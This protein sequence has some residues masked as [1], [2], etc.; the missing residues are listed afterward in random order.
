MVPCPRPH[1]EF[2]GASRVDWNP[3][4]SPQHAPV[5][6]PLFVGAKG[7]VGLLTKVKLSTGGLG[8]APVTAPGHPLAALLR[9]IFHHHRCDTLDA[10]I[11]A[12][13]RRGGT[14]GCGKARQEVLSGERDA[15]G[16]RE[17]PAYNSRKPGARRGGRRG[18]MHHPP[19]LGSP[20]VMS[21]TGHRQEAGGCLFC[22]VPSPVEEGVTM[23]NAEN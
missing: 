5:L 1:S 20:G 12:P 19:F 21:G 10:P 11:T 14:R 8:L 16:G 18:G 15:G 22:R 17:A 2:R 6:W 7:G 23:E 9:D 3:G 4:L 13:G